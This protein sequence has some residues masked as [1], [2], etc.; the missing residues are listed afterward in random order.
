MNGNLSEQHPRTRAFFSDTK[1]NV[2][3]GRVATLRWCDEAGRLIDP[4]LGWMPLPECT[5]SGLS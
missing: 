1:G 5:S 4:P 3:I 2:L